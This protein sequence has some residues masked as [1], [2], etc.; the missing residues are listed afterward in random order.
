LCFQPPT[1]LTD[2]WEDWG[3]VMTQPDE[4]G[5]VEGRP[6]LYL[7]GDLNLGQEYGKFHHIAGES[8]KR[9][10][11]ILDQAEGIDPLAG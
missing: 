6:L 7:I 9:Q 11:A 1:P 8:L 3:L 10:S 2:N 4:F 5:E